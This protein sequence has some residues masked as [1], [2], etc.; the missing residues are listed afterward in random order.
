MAFFTTLYSGSSGN[1]GVVWQGE[2]YLMIDVGK[3]CRT[4]LSALKEQE[5]DP[6]GLRGIL[7]THEHTDHIGGLSVFLKK[8]PVPVYAGDETLL[9]LEEQ[10]I[11][12]AGVEAIPLGEA[13]EEIG[14]FGVKAFATSHDVPCC[15]FRIETPDHKVMSIATDLGTLT[16][17]VHQN[18]A[19]ANLVALESNYDRECL[20]CG[21]YPY[22]LKKR[23]ESARGHLSNDEC[24]AKLL[25]LMQEGC[26]RFA[27]CHMSKENNREDLVLGTLRRLLLEAGLMP[28]KGTRVQVQKRSEVS[29]VL[30]F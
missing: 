20:R 28:E 11:L 21:P 13:Q 14:G 18:L 19:G 26:R 27:L 5:L 4:T 3:S 15:G 30:D 17:V 1:C 9:H 8:N 7:I 6:R 10:G 24:S 2:E 23:I 12:P 16:P 22:Y 29:Q 25:E